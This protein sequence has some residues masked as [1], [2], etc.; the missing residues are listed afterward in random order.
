MT[1]LVH[2]R[3]ELAAALKPLRHRAFVPTM[4]ALHD[5]HAALI[6]AAGPGAVVSIFVNPLQFGVGEDLDRYPRTL[7]ADVALCA[8]HGAAVVWA[9]GVHDVYVGGPPSVTVHAG[10]IGSRYEGESRPGHFD[11]MLTV[12]AKLFGIVR[13]DVAYFGQKDAQQLAL[14]RQLVHDLDLGVEIREVATVREPDGL[15]LSSRNRYL[16][17]RERTAAVALSRAVLSGSLTEARS[18]LAAAAGV[19]VDYCDLVDPETFAPTT[20]AGRL[21]VAA[22]VGTTHLIDN[23][24][25]HVP[26]RVLVSA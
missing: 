5:G 13:P 8:D 21:V 9:P 18:I 14:V 1:T 25:A 3:A 15:A 23:A 20:G 11:G 7:A 26:A 4:G 6:D 12:V 10:E 2:T 24:P 22:R 17:R 16:S 19:A